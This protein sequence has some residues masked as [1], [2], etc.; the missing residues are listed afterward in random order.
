M[1]PNNTESTSKLKEKVKATERKMKMKIQHI[2]IY[3]M[4][5]KHY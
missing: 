5:Q 1:L 2:K 4:Q 3:G